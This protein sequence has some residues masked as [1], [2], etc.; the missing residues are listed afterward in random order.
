M[1]KK[2]KN[3]NSSEPQVI[4]PYGYMPYMPPEDDTIDLRQLWQTLKKRKVTVFL[5]AFLFLLLAGLYLLI[6][7]PKYEAKATLEIGKELMKGSGSIPVAKHFDDARSL[8]QYLD[9]KYDTAGK[10]RNKNST[11]YISSVTVLKKGATKGFITITAIGTSN[12][13]A[14]N[15]IKK[16]I[17]EVIKKHKIYYETIIKKQKEKIKSLEQQIQFYEKNT[18]PQ[19]IRRVNYLE[20]IELKNIDNRIETIVKEDLE[21]YKKRIKDIQ[22]EIKKRTEAIKLL[23]KKLLDAK[24]DSSVSTI[25]GMQIADYEN[26]IRE[27]YLKIKELDSKIKTA[28]NVTIPSLMDRK[29]ELL[30]VTIPNIRAKIK[31]IKTVKIPNLEYNIENI[32]T[33]MKEPYLVMTKVV[34]QIYTHDKPVKPKKGLTLVVA[35]ITGVMVGVFLAFF[36]EFIG[37]QPEKMES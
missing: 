27:M 15:T 22:V 16:P 19:L 11:S 20:T 23:E 33:S 13:E 29:S 32:K 10:Y 6:V 30:E 5:T 2:D 35:L 1:D 14:I 7:K 31:E 28:E 37:K 8:K 25:I 34:G 9:V 26:S 18:L 21:E 3:K 12:T 17:S 4:V 36:L 24:N